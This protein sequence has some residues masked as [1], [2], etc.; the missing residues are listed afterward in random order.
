MVNGVPP[1]LGEGRRTLR[2]AR[3]GETSDMLVFGTFRMDP[4]NQQ[5][6]WGSRLVSL[7]P[8]TFAV[9]RYLVERPQRLITKRE[10][11][12]ALW[13][14]VY[15]GEDVLKTHLKEIRQALG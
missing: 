10:L 3:H 11:L 2:A 14:D 9:L 13:H 12:D 1:W 5:L 8:K 6:W 15:V 7:P 4:L